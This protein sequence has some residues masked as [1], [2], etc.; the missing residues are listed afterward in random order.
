M[1]FILARIHVGDYDAWKPSFDKDL[2]GTRRDATRH[3]VFR[4]VDDPGEVVVQVE[5]E[6]LEQ[7]REARDR[8]V[9]SGVLN[10]FE[11]KHGPIVVEVAEHV[12][13]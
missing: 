1:A 3:R 7:A 2:P 8:L 12:D 13:H 6:T 9:Q 5:F 10:R 11:D 4:N